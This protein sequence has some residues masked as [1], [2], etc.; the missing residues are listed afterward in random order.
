MEGGRRIK[1]RSVD[2]AGVDT[3]VPLGVRP[4]EGVGC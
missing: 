2:G 3:P 1:T 4:L